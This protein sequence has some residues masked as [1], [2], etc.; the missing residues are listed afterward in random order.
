VSCFDLAQY[1][2]QPEAAVLEFAVLPGQQDGQLT[3]E[4]PPDARIAA[5]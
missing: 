3:G 5:M 1:R 4:I 2:A